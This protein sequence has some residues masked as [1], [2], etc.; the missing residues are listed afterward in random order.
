MSSNPAAYEKMFS[1]EAPQLLERMASAHSSPLEF[2]TATQANFGYNVRL[3]GV[4]HHAVY[5][6]ERHDPNI[7]HSPEMPAGTAFLRGAVLAVQVARVVFRPNEQDAICRSNAELMDVV[8]QK[9]D[10]LGIVSERRDEE[11]Y[12][13]LSL[14]AE[15][16]YAH[17]PAYHDLIDRWGDALCPVIP[18]QA[19]LRKGAGYMS[20]LIRFHQERQEMQADLPVVWTDANIAALIDGHQ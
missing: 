4:A 8:D 16:G 17:M 13:E 10:L 18:L 6:I 5:Y 2:V 3:Y 11:R 14:R 12:W 15:E 19:F 1:S 9:L 7:G 20:H